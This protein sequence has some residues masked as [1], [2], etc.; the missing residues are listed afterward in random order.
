MGFSL[1]SSCKHLARRIPGSVN[2]LTMLRRGRNRV[3]VT[4][5][6]L[7]YTRRAKELGS[8]PTPQWRE[9]LFVLHNR[10]TH[11]SFDRHYVYH[12][13]WAMRQLL[14]LA[15]E[16]H[17]DISSSLYFVALG[18]AVIPMVHLDYRPPLLF[19][20]NLE[21]SNGDLMALPFGDGTV[22]SLSCLHV[23]EHVGLGRYGDP[24]DPTADA[25]ACVELERVLSPGGTLL[26]VTPVGRPRVVFNAHRIYSFGM[27]QKLFRGL[28]M[29]EWALI[30]DDSKLGILPN[31]D[32]EVV[33][34][35]SYGCG[36]FVFQKQE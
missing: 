13:A 28:E 24:V 11:T 9:R 25:N 17:V 3:R 22:P 15:P 18:S 23:I 35:Q 7:R 31:A 21:C 30:P 29:R 36:C 2:I 6:F 34:A 12:T 4:F 1:I 26:F 10:T 14:R 33:D 8:V 27:I 5:D 32:P 19:L 20:D 16:K